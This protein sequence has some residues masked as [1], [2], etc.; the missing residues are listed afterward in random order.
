[1]NWATPDAADAQAATN[2]RKIVRDAEA[3]P[4]AA[5]TRPREIARRIER[6]E[7]TVA[8][9]MLPTDR[10]ELAALAGAAGRVSANPRRLASDEMHDA[11]ADRDMRNKREA[12]LASVAA[13]A[14]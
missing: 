14:T 2:L 11:A 10:T 9:R 12:A 4:L 1:M 5:A 6:A 7:V 13:A 8:S 3:V